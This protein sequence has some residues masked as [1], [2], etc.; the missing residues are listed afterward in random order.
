MSQEIR[1]IDDNS[2]GVL[3]M[4]LH[5]RGLPPAQRSAI[6]EADPN[7]RVHLTWRNAVI[8][9]RAATV[10]AWIEIDEMTEGA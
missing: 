8:T 10:L 1:P 7:D 9:A 3:D 6:A 5:I 4:S 2:A